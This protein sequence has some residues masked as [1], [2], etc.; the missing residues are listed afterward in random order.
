MKLN[1]EEEIK[2]KLQLEVENR[3]VHYVNSNNKLKNVKP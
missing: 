2:M 3:K 1:A